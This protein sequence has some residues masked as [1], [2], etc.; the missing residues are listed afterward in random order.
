MLISLNYPC[1]EHILMVPKVLKPLKFYCLCATHSFLL[2]YRTCLSLTFQGCSRVFRR[3]DAL[4]KHLCYHST[5]YSYVCDFCGKKFK[6]KTCMVHHRKFHLTEFRWSCDYCKDKFKTCAAFKS[7]IARLHTDKKDEV[8]QRTNIKFYPCERCPKVYGEK[9][10]YDQHMNIHLGL[11][12]FLCVFCEKAFSS[13]SNMIQHKKT[14]TGERKL[15]CNLCS[16][17]YSD[18]KMFKM[19]LENKHSQTVD[20]AVIGLT[21]GNV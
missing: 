13:R 6:E 9:K 18:P 5:E 14:H 12:P 8:S 19:H 7:H 16:K 10:E 4:K 1:L 3:W 15:R 21:L 2:H 20:D 17:A 11:K